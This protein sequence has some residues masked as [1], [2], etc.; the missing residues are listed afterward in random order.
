MVH[1]VSLGEMNATRALITLLS[2]ERP[3]A[4]F[5]VSTTT[6][7]GHE[8]GQELYGKSPNV[9]LVR[10]P[11]DFSAAVER[12]LD[13]VRPDVVALMEL[14]VW[15]NF[16]RACERRGIR[17]VLVNG[18]LTTTS[19][20]NYKLGRPVAAAMFRRLAGIC[21]QDATYQERFIDLGAPPGRVLVTGTMK[22]DTALTSETV[23]GGAELAK[24]VGLHP[25]LERIWVC[26]STGP[27]EEEIILRVYR[28]LLVRFPRMRLAIVPRHPERFD[29]VAGLIEQARLRVFRRSGDMRP[30]HPDTVAIPPVILGDTIGELRKFYSL[31]DVVFVGRSITDLGPRQH[32]SD[33]IEPAALAKPVVVGPYTDN[34]AEAVRKFLAADAMRVAN[35]EDGLRDVVSAFLQ[36]P[37]AAVALG[38]RAAAVVALERGATARNARVIL[39]QLLLREQLAAGARH[40]PAGEQAQAA[41]TGANGA[42]A[43]E[44]TAAADVPAESSPTSS[45]SV[46][47]APPDRGRGGITFTPADIAPPTDTPE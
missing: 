29:E 47:R 43:G 30:P 24:A 23:E 9:T 25:G 40:P 1:A 5:V 45:P 34:F 11:L 19:Y 2:A 26:G 32:G 31:A 41:A 22:F 7:T 6:K 18:R 17:V 37:Q 33:M 4:R 44:A 28:E 14:E 39:G 10:Y 15:P 21:V 16:L 20:R 8:R 13:S 38:R 35:D 46:Q 3:D 42:Q 12:F 36:D 27:G